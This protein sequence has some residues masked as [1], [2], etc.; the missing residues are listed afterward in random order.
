MN[1]VDKKVLGYLER[2]IALIG[3]V[4]TL[5]GNGGCFGYLEK[6]D[7]RVIEIAKMIQKE[8]LKNDNI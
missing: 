6:G 7:L 5:S 2:A 3:P 4:T 1:K 8:A